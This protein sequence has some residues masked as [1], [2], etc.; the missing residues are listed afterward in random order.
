MENFPFKIGKIN[1]CKIY[2]PQLNTIHFNKEFVFI[3][4]LQR[5]HATNHFVVSAVQ[6]RNA[7]MNGSL[8]P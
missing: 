1:V 6:Q 3:A 5:S 2:L 4:L 7:I 8:L